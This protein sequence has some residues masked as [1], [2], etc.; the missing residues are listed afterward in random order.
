M[1]MR[2]KFPR[3]LLIVSVLAL[4][5]ALAGCCSTCRQKLLEESV[6]QE[7][8]APRKATL[9]NSIQL[10]SHSEKTVQDNSPL[11]KAPAQKASPDKAA[12]DKTTQDKKAPE[13]VS[14]ETA[15]EA[16]CGKQGLVGRLRDKCA[17]I[18]PGAIPQPIGT[19]T[20]ELI[21]RQ[22]TKAELDQFVIYLYE[23]QGNSANLGPFGARHIDRIAARLAGGTFPVVIEPDCDAKRNEARKLAVVAFLESRGI[24]NAN[25]SVSVAFPQAEGLLGDEAERIYRQMIIPRGGAYNSGNYGNPGAYGN[26]YN[27]QNGGGYGGYGYGGY[28]AYG[29]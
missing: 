26:R 6:S 5:V 12:P 22:V 18:P 1:N 16:C 3:V 13:A 19:H 21:S 9:V 25:Q 14:Q 28:G 24:A 7:K 4:P 27:V 8:P 11:D 20:N 15:G 23:W 10:M 17:T 29:Y 2:P